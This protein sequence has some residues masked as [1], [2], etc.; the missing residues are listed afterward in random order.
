[1]R[2]RAS[3]K[4]RRHHAIGIDIADSSL[5]LVNIETLKD[6]NLAI[7][8]HAR[9]TLPSRTIVHGTI[10]DDRDLDA[11]LTQLFIRAHLDPRGVSV[12]SALPDSQVLVKALPLSGISSDES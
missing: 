1:M 4:K 3:E 10:R 5:E 2:I 7:N 12:V 11:A 8:E 6:G 9:V